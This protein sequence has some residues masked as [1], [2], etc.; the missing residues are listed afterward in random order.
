MKFHRRKFLRLAAGV[1]ALPAVARIAQAQSY[2]TRPVRI[3]IGQPPGTAP[4]TLARL[5]AQLLSERLGQ[6]FIVENR[7]G[8]GT[9]IATEAVVRAPGDG[10]TLLLSTLTSA[11]N[12]T[13]Y[14]NLSF[15]FVRDIAPVAII[16][17]NAFV[18]VVTPSLPTKTVPEF[19]AYAKANPG[20]I[21]MA[22]AGSGTAPHV[23]G[24]L[25][26][27]MAGVDLVHVQYRG[28]FYPDLFAGRVQVAFISI[29]GA[30]ANIR[31]GKL[32]A[33]AVTTVRRSDLLLDVPPL[34]EFVPGYEASAWL[35]VGV[36]KNTPSGII[37]KLNQEIN[38]VTADPSTKAR[39]V[40]LGVEPMAMTPTAFGKF[41][42]DEAAKWSKVIKSANIKAE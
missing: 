8:A 11:I 17:N 23:F 42:V 4:D 14:D 1:A 9:N 10:Y 3:I 20:K 16:G 26:K 37:A 30:I 35:G 31:D 18:M 33:L 21:N 12:D 24:E 38:A 40:G 34:G 28:S 29:A 6:S 19:I 13:L 27:Q 15:N 32:R 7:P 41:T 36:P 39:L 25:F 22:S 2:P 5:L